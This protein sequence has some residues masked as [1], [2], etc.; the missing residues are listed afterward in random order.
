MVYLVSSV[1]RVEAAGLPWVAS[2]ANCASA[3]T[4]F[5]SSVE[6]L[7]KLI[8]WP[9][10]QE[11]IWKSTDEDPD[12]KRR[13]MAEFLVHREF[14]L[15]IVAGYVVRTRERRHELQQVLTAAGTNDVYVDVRP[16]WYY[17]YRRRE[18]ET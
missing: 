17:G 8:D 11:K 6:E 18:V 12:R 2:D 16:D 15:E 10:M 9:L 7:A 14:P 13:R 4:R 1:D 5:S 3:L